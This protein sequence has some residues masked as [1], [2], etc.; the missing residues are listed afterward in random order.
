MKL[1]LD[2]IPSTNCLYPYVAKIR[3][4][5]DYAYIPDGATFILE[6]NTADPSELYNY[7]T[8]LRY[9]AYGVYM[10][11]E[12]YRGGD[13]VPSMETTLFDITD[14]I[15]NGEEFIYMAVSPEVLSGQK[16]LLY[17]L[18]YNYGL[19]YESSDFALGYKPVE[20]Q[21]LGGRRKTNIVPERQLFRGTHSSSKYNRQAWSMGKDLTFLTN[22]PAIELYTDYVDVLKIDHLSRLIRM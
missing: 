14:K 9:M 3:M 6:Q 15:R 13:P 2:F 7:E 10:S 11:Y 4:E 5:H 18:E 22:V 12:I 8:M 20:R 1:Y 17:R 16:S 19:T 21:P